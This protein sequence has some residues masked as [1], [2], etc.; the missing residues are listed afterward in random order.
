[1][2]SYITTLIREGCFNSLFLY[3]LL[4]SSSEFTERLP[5]RFEIG[6]LIVEGEVD[7][8]PH[9]RDRDLHRCVFSDLLDDS[10]RDIHVDVLGDLCGSEIDCFPPDGISPER[11]VMLEAI[12]TSIL[13]DGQSTLVER[14]IG[15]GEGSGE[16][17]THREGE[18]GFLRTHPPSIGFSEGISSGFP[19]FL[20]MGIDEGFSVVE[21]AF[22]DAEEIGELDLHPAETR[23]TQG[24]RIA[25][26][27][28]GPTHVRAEMVE[29]RGDRIHSSPEIEIA[30]KVDGGFVAEFLRDLELVGRV[31]TEGM[32]FPIDLFAL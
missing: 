3:T 2:P 21:G 20:E 24:F 7:I 14:G 19:H 23:G 10:I 6:R 16:F 30:R 22:V 17:E 31:A 25:E 4:S 8:A 9:G 5:Q 13:M 26:E 12:A 29:I 11:C 27:E 15:R 1:M 28:E 32:D 18:E